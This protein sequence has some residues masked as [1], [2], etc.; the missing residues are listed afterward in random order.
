[1]N[2]H[3]L[4]PVGEGRLHL[5]RAD[6]LGD[7][8]H[9]VVG[10]QQGGSVGHEIGDRASFAGPLEDF[11]GDVGDCLGVIESDTPVLASSRQVC[12]DDDE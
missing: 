7:S 5:D 6:H 11:S 3:E 4:G 10:G 2:G 12:G 9:D 1:M 8:L